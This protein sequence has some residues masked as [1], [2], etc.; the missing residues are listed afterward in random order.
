MN[1]KLKNAIETLNTR[2]FDDKGNAPIGLADGRM[3][4]CIYFFYISRVCKSEEYKQKA[5]SLI[6]EILEQAANTKMYDIK[7]GLAG[8]GLGV[9]YLVEN[10]YV[11]GDINDILEDVD[12]ILFKQIANLEK[13]EN[14]DISLQLQLLY[15]FVVRLKKQ[16]KNSENEYLFREA[17]IDAINFISEKIYLL[18]QEESLSFNME[19]TSIQ[20]LFVLS[21]C[22]ELYKDKITRILKEISFCTLSKVPVLHSNRLYLLYAMD[23]V[24]KKIETKGWSEHIKLLA[25]ETDIEYIIE[26]E[27]ADELYFSNGLSAIYFLLSGLDDYFSSDQIFKYKRQIINKIE[28]SPIWNALLNNED[29]LKRKSGLF[30]GYAGISLLLHTTLQR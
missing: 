29:Y 13:K 17:I 8:I 20:S 23:K 30:S 26:K 21:H 10:K 22:G 15:Y 28:N 25:R 4:L 3:G 19:N 7:N 14:N 1:M 27:L 24:N 18:F 5:E 16:S 12:N 6:D 2:V 11:E 9:D